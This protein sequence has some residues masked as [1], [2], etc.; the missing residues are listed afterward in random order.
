MITLHRIPQTL[1][2]SGPEGVGKAT[3][4][5]RFA[6]RLLGESASQ[7]MAL[8]GRHRISLEEKI[9][10]DDLSREE[11]RT[12]IADREK[13]TGEKRG[14]D[15][16]F[17]STYADF[18]TFC[19]EGPLRQISIPQMRLVR[20]RSQLLPSRGRWRVFLIDQF[21]RASHQ[22]A[23]SLLKTLEEP[24]P[25]LILFM[26]A[27][28]PFD[29]PPTIRSRSVQFHLS[30]ISDEEMLSFAKSRGLKDAEKRLALSGGCP[31]LACSMD[32]Q[33][34]EKRRTAL[35]ALL[36][37]AAGGSFAQWV[38]RSE[39]LIASKSEKL[40]LYFKILYGLLEDLLLLMHG[41][42]SVRNQDIAGDLVRLAS[43]VNFAWIREAIAF[44]DEL[45][46]LQRRNV[47]KGPS[48][49]QG[50]IRLRQVRVL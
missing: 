9:E 43:R 31:G 16:L 20:D 36:D 8:D 41:K 13:W 1:L 35:L 22:V 15:P 26:T 33:L 19:P 17:F 11:N 45:I 12:I 28:N 18:V 14:D 42:T 3:L 24:P 29:L 2:L 23:D 30:P 38:Q 50:V 49:D 10:Q 32:L 34:Y 37:A 40:D 47:Q 6:A 48:L 5:R 7:A 21:D 39:S 44:T 25:H 27:E 46:G 4:V